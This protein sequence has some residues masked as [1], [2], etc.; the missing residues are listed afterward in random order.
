[1]TSGSPPGTTLCAER[2]TERGGA[3]MGPVII[4]DG[5]CN[6]CN[7]TVDFLIRRD[8]RGRLR[9]ASN[10]SDAGRRL[11]GER[12]IPDADVQSIYFVEGDRVSARSTAA[13]RIAR[14]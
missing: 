3:A 1:T 6:L 9:F 10:Q 5:V 7:A 2:T 8:R 13:L 11:L 12:G 4:F 14:L